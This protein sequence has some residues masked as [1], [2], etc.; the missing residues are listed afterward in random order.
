MDVAIFW[1]I[2]P[3]SPHVNRRFEGAYRFHLQ[4]RKSAEQDTSVQ[5]VAGKAFDPEYG[6]D[7]F[8]RNV[9]LH[10]NYTALYPKR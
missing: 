3:C 8:P 5:E 4:G 9:A 10:T 2:E 1:D 6:T 7:T